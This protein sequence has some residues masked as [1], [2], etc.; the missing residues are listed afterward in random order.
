[1]PNGLRIFTENGWKPLKAHTAYSLEQGRLRFEQKNLEVFFLNL[2]G[3]GKGIKVEN[4]S[5]YGNR[6]IMPENIKG[7]LLVTIGKKY[8]NFCFN[9]EAYGFTLSSTDQT[10]VE[11]LG[12]LPDF[13]KK[14]F[15][16]DMITIKFV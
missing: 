2:I 6:I 12:I 4:S 14:A 10:N 16:D 15:G 3:E 13:M 5:T 11:C 7:K 1:M 9:G 8:F